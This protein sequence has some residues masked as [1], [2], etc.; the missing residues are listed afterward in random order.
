MVNKNNLVSIIIPCYNMG[1]YIMDAVDSAV[2]QTYPNIEIIIVDDASTDKKTVSVLQKI[3]NDNVKIFYLKK[4]KGL[5]GARNY[6]I[7]KGT[8]KY[9]LPL[10]ADDKIHPEYITKAIRIL[11][12]NKEIGIVYSKAELFGNAKGAFVLPR[13]SLQT[14]LSRNVIFCSAV[15]RKT[16]WL[17]V[18][19]YEETMRSGLEDYDFWLKLIYHGV[20]V[21]CLSSVMFYY[22]IRKNSMFTQTIFFIDKEILVKKHIY[23]NNELLY[24]ENTNLL[25][26]NYLK[27]YELYFK[28]QKE[29][30]EKTKFLKA[31]SL[32]LPFFIIRKIF[33]KVKNVI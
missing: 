11:E 10:D 21:H 1:K 6:A 15:F 28:S 13:Y 16:D 19:G 29:Y 31:F 18:G 33:R 9:I 24:S 5:P 25:Y 3:K 22:R 7:Q 30:A 8:G 12:K 2:A 14:M 17:K 26:L 20:K 27:Y 4:N 23:K 32:L